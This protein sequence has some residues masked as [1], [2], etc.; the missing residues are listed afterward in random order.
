MEKK[1]SFND[2][3]KIEWSSLDEIKHNIFKE[4]KEYKELKRKC[5]QKK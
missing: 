1:K 2:L 3:I 4:L 5:Q